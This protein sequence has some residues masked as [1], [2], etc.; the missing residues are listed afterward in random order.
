MYHVRRLQSHVSQAA[1]GRGE[2][3]GAARGPDDG[4][5]DYG[6]LGYYGC[7][8]YGS[9]FYCGRRHARRTDRLYLPSLYL[10]WQAAWKEERQQRAALEDV[11]AG[12]LGEVGTAPRGLG[13]GL[14]LG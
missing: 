5:G 12:S 1:A 6:Y 14:G 3:V 10:L 2:R 11:L 13:P 9:T 7:T 4:T 8:H